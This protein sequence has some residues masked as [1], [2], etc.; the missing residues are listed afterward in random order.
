MT[1]QIL[2]LGCALPSNSLL[3]S[4]LADIAYHLS[5]RHS[6]SAKALS[7]LYRLTGVAKRGSVLLHD[8]SPDGLYQ[9][10]LNSIEREGDSAINYGPSTAQRMQVFSE[11][12]LPLAHRAVCAA[13]ADSAV[14]VEEI[15]DLVTVSCTGFQAPGIDLALCK[16]LALPASVHRTHIGFMGCHGALNG[17]RVAN[18]H[19][20]SNPNSTVLLV[21]VEL[22]SLH[23]NFSGEKDHLVS[24][25]LFA[26]GAAALIMRNRT[27]DR[28]GGIQIPGNVSY[29]VPNSEEMMSWKVGNNGFVMQL[30]PRVPGIIEEALPEWLG[31]ELGNAGLSISEIGGWAVHPGGPRIL[32]A[33]RRALDLNDNALEPS[34]YILEGHGNMSSPTVLFILEELRRRDLARPWVILAFG[35]GLTIELAILM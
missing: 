16:S 19:C 31:H 33:T 27:A 25:A 11:H 28:E 24:N 21:A 22:C 8:V 5:A 29:I 32:E 4:E 10:Y 12:A 30:S 1:T 34:K 13:L 26:D 23:Y 17:M 9:F 35:P 20:A 7:E 2:G 15:T 18:S 3:Q 14:S 6:C